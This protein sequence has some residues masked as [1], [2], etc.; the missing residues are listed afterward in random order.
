MPVLLAPPRWSGNVVMDTRKLE[1]IRITALHHV[2]RYNLAY[3]SSTSCQ[4]RHAR[5]KLREGGKPSTH[6]RAW[7]T[8]FVLEVERIYSSSVYACSAG[9]AAAF[10][11]LQAAIDAA[12]LDLLI[13]GCTRRLAGCRAFVEEA[14]KAMRPGPQNRK[15]RHGVAKR[16]SRSDGYQSMKLIE[17]KHI[18]IDISRSQHPEATCASPPAELSLAECGMGILPMNHGRD[19]RATRDQLPILGLYKTSKEDIYDVA[20]H[21]G[22]SQ[23]LA[24][25]KF[26]LSPA[27]G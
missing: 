20:R 2:Q 9:T 21:T 10:D 23:E 25:T 13:D 5:R 11:L 18:F 19:A 4:Y 1:T 14:N 27:E 26:P 16:R 17:R 12:L 7:Y 6:A 3:P 22:D 24:A 8:R 15:P